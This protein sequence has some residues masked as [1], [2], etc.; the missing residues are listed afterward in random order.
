VNFPAIG[1]GIGQGF[2]R[3]IGTG[4]GPVQLAVEADADRLHVHRRGVLRGRWKLNVGPIEP[5]IEIFEPRA[6]V[7]RERIFKA[8]AGGPAEADVQRLL[9]LARRQRVQVSLA[10]PGKAAGGIGKP[11][12]ARIADP[13]TRCS[14]KVPLMDDI[15]AR[16]RQ[17]RDDRVGFDVARK[18]DVRLGAEQQPRGKLDIVAGLQAAD[19]AAEIVVAGGCCRIEKCGRRPAAAKADVGAEIESGP[20]DNRLGDRLDGAYKAEIRSKSKA[21]RRQRA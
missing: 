7:R 3:N 12:A 18:R 19:D 20:I 10:G 4:R 13:A 21:V 6:P 17:R 9:L 11:G 1:F 2:E 14:D 16:G 8:R 5:V 15:G